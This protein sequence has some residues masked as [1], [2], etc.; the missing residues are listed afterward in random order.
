MSCLL[1]KH[2]IPCPIIF[3]HLGQK[4]KKM[5]ENN[6]SEWEEVIYESSAY[7]IDEE[8]ERSDFVSFDSVG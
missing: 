6:R 8:V 3:S 5:K 4:K 2:E 1:M 7:Y